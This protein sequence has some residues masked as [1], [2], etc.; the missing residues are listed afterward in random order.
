[1]KAK[2]FIILSLIALPIVGPMAMGNHKILPQESTGQYVD[3]SVITLKVKSKLLAD[4]DL[5]SLAISVM[6]YKGQV[7]LTGFVDTDAEKLQATKLAKQVE[8]V[9]NVTNALIVKKMPK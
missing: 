7:K 3:N 5:K 9:T 1:M 8:G 4:P 6:S 2:L